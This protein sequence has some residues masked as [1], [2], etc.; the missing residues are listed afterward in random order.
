VLSRQQLNAQ[1]YKE[2]RRSS[3]H[4]LCKFSE[5]SVCCPAHL[6]AI[7][8][9]APDILHQRMFSLSTRSSYSV[10]QVA[11]GYRLWWKVNVV[12]HKAS[13]RIRE[14]SDLAVEGDRKRKPSAEPSSGNCLIQECCHVVVD[15][16]WRSAM[17]KNTW[18]VFR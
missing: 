3:F 15:E 16:W 4:T 10:L 9:F 14:V 17:L 1:H 5:C 7:S 6:K 2:H 11:Q 18:F 13:R 12:F 8:D